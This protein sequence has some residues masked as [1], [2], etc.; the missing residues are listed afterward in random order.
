MKDKFNIDM[1]TKVISSY[2]TSIQ[3]RAK[4]GP[5]KKRGRKPGQTAAALI[6]VVP[7]APAKG[8][9]ISLDDIRAVKELANRLGAD[10]LSELAAVLAR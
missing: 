6:A 10:K 3:A 4:K 7:V 5:G 8:G 2:K 1:P 9:G